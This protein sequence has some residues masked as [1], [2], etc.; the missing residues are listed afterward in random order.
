ERIGAGLDHLTDMELG[1]L[2]GAAKRGARRSF[3]AASPSRASLPA[4]P[5]ISSASECS[6][7]GQAARSQWLSVR[8]VKAN[9]EGLPAAS[10]SAI[11]RARACNASSGTERLT[12]PMRSASSP[13]KGAQVSRWYLAL[14]MPH[15]K[16]Q[17][18]AA[19][20]PA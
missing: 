17:M 7:A 9:A 16:G 5:I 15:S 8:L 13:L 1:E 20:S 2:H 4:K 14:A 3:K 6:K 18:M 10:S 11:W 12:S 19:W